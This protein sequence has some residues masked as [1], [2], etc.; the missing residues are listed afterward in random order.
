MGANQ[1][2]R[3]EERIVRE[4]WLAFVLLAAAMAQT[5][6]LPR[7]FGAVP[8]V[9]LLIIICRALINGP[10]NAARWAFYAGLGLDLFADS[11][12][13]THALALLL[14]VL[15]ATLPLAWLSR[16]NWLL[17]LLGVVLGSLGYQAMF[18]LL[19]SLLTAPIDLRAYITV[20]ALPTTVL[21]L[22]PAL[23]LF[24][25]LRWFESRRRGEVPIDVY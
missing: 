2:K 19:N 8:N 25:S 3:I 5:T 22:I 17:P 13:G 18:I 14:A 24:L 10:A 7:L 21:L 12:L 4:I 23:P 9:L 6:L 1:P 15:L 20:V 11:A 16:G